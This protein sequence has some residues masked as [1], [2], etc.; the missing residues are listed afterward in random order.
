[1]KKIHLI[2]VVFLV[3]LSGCRSKPSELDADAFQKWVFDRDNGLTMEKGINRVTVAAQLLPKEYLAYREWKQSQTSNYDSLLKPY[4]CGLSFQV[5]LQAEKSDKE[6]G[7]L[8]YYNIANQEEYMSRT[9]FLS[10]G[11]EH[12]IFIEDGSVRLSPVLTS[13]EGYD[14]LSNKVSFQVV[15]MVPEYNCGKPKSDFKN[16]TLRF[17][18]PY[19]NLGNVNFEFAREDITSIP[20]LRR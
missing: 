4:A 5:S 10:F 2:A 12:F 3:S 18:D 20:A 16:L 8:M 17:E 6:Y 9:R 19:W 11:A 7:N 15:F 1:M 13:F 14:P